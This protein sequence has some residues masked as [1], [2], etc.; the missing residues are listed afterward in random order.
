MLIQAGIAVDPPTAC[1]LVWGGR[2]EKAD[3]TNQFVWWCLNKL[4]VISTSVGSIESHLLA[5]HV[6]AKWH[7]S[8]NTVDTD[9]HGYSLACTPVWYSRE[10]AGFSLF[11]VGGARGEKST[12]RYDW[13]DNS[14][15]VGRPRLRG[16]FF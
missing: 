7:I 1:H 15:V 2:Y 16:N 11:P 14:A 13:L 4:A 8:Q 3:L 9:L 6:E 5:T 10:P 12:E